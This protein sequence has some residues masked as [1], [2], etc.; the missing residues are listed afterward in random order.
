MKSAPELLRVFRD[1]APPYVLEILHVG[2][3]LGGEAF[4]IVDEPVGIRERDDLGAHHHRLFRRELGHVARTGDRDDLAA[5]AVAPRVKHLLGEIDQ[6]IAGGLLADAAAAPVDALAGEHAGELIAQL[7]VI[8]V[9]EADFTAAHADVA[10][11]HVGV[12]ADVAE[13]LAHERLAEMHHFLVRLALGVEIRAALAAAHGESRQRVL[14]HLFEGQELQRA[15]P[16]RGMEAQSALVRPNRAVHL[17]PVSAIDLHL[18]V[19]VHPGHAK[20]DGALRFGQPLE[21]AGLPILRVLLN[22][23]PHGF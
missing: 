7:L 19:A 2:E 23:R 12:G 14:Q 10:G 20:H 9:E 6:A 18:S 16:H 21:D 3:L 13:Q 1:A 15:Q 8:A 5:H 4:A 17:D 11:R 22:E